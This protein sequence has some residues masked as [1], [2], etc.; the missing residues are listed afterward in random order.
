MN[1]TLLIGFMAAALGMIAFFPQVYKSI[2]TKHTKD[3][4]LPTFSIVAATN[5]LWFV[6]GILKHDIPLTLANGV[7]FIS[8][9]IIL[10]AKLKYG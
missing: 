4:S 2:K 10:A 9:L 7:I 5:F 6:Y 8:V 3:V 1:L